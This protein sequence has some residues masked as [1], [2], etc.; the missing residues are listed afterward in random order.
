VIAKNCEAALGRQVY[1]ASDKEKLLKTV[2]KEIYCAELVQTCRECSTAERQVR[3]TE[4]SLCAYCNH[5]NCEARNIGPTWDPRSNTDGH[6]M[7]VAARA[8]NEAA[9]QA[10]RPRVTRQS[11][12][13][14]R[15]HPWDAWSTAADES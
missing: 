6:P 7:S 8:R 4:G 11:R 1:G 15:A 5:R 12:E 9:L 2:A 13:M 14:G 10:E 3:A